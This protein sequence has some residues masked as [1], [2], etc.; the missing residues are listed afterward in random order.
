MGRLDEVKPNVVTPYLTDKIWL[1]YGEMATRKT[2]VACS[3]PGHVLF[4]FDIGYKLINGAMA[5]P[6]QTWAD[7]KNTV[8]E[9]DKK[10]NKERFSTVI[11]D[12][13][14]MAYQACYQYMLTQMGINDPGEIKFGMAWRRIR[15][16]FETVVRSIV[17]KGYGLVMLAHSDEVES[18]DK[19]TKKKIVTTKVDIDKRPGLII[20]GL[21]DFAL[22]LKKE[23]RDGTDDIPTV[24]AYSDLVTIDTKRRSRYF[25]PRF[26]F[27]YDN[28][29]YELQNAVQR[30]YSAEGT[31][32]PETFEI[33]N[34]YARPDISFS[35]LRASVIGMAQTLIDKGMEN[36]VNEVLLNVFK[37]IRLSEVEETQENI[38]RLQVIHETLADLVSKAMV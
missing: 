21:A 7:F 29:Q 31:Q 30:Q 10:S 8:R 28:L 20:K 13:I 33:I 16:E 36:E 11:I 12:T 15:D 26:E 32:M 38:N 14:G 1:F 9:L 18:E 25:S 17:Q 23:P 2:S 4:A 19:D 6:M 5:V 34:P 3:F 37:G 24:Y 27:T 35:E 22:F